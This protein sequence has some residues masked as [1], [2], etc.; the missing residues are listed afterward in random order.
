M[1]SNYLTLEVACSYNPNPRHI[2]VPRAIESK[3]IFSVCGELHKG[4]NMIHI[5]ISDIEWNNTYSGSK[6]NTP[7]P[8][9]DTDNKKRRNQDLL[10]Y[11]SRYKKNKPTKTEPQ[12]KVEEKEESSEK[13]DKD[14]EEDDYTKESDDDKLQNENVEN[15]T[16]RS[17]KLR[18]AMKKR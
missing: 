17:F 13:R 16:S 9:Q 11:E 7:S 5:V 6:S 10:S 1:T 8:E 12:V 4:D 15:V 14:P 18:S 3:A 2:G